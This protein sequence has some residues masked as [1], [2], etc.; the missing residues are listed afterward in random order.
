[1]NRRSV[2]ALLSAPFSSFGQ[3]RRKQEAA[4]RIEVRELKAG[5]AEGRITLDGVIRNTGARALTKLVLLFDLQ[6]ADRKTISRR[7]GAVEEPVLEPGDEYSFNFYVADHARA[8]E[9]T[10]AAEARGLE[11]NVAKAGPYLIE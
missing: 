3:Q 7:R 4:S 11:I 1:M 9:V 6:D 10:V 2:L 5:R 8:V